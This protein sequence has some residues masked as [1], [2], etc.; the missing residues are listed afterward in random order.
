MEHTDWPMGKIVR[1]PAR[2]VLAEPDSACETLYEIVEGWILRCEVAP[3]GRRE[4]VTVFMPGDLCDPLW[5]HHPPTQT[6]VAAAAATVRAIPLADLRFPGGEAGA[7]RHARL[8]QQAARNDARIGRWMINLAQRSASE[9]IGLLLCEIAFRYNGDAE[10]IPWLFDREDLANCVGLTAPHA[11]RVLRDFRLLG[12]ASV[13]RKRLT[14]PDL[15]RLVRATGFD[16]AY[17]E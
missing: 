6:Y 14:I 2:S 13:N 5:L 12:L 7:S 4:I 11:A 3:D 8:W 10:Q 1:L 16:A 17:L 9:R 15:D